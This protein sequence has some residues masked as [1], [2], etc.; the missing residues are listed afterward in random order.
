MARWN[1]DPVLLLGFAVAIAGFVYFGSRDAARRAWFAAATGILAVL[2]V[3]PFCALTSAL[4]AA[5]VAHHVVLTAV[6]APLLA[7]A[8]P[9][10]PR[11]GIALWAG[12]HALVFWVWH[13]PPVYG[14]ALSSH[15]AYWLMQAT[16]LGS[17]VA[18]WS[19]VRAAPMPAA[20]A[21]LLATMVQM[22]LLGALITFAPA[23]LYA[24]HYLG[25]IAWGFTPLEDQQLAGLIMW[26]PGAAVYLAAALA[27]LSRWFARE[28][29]AA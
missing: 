8:L 26:A 12:L 18:L 22:G 28:Q 5:R 1:F 15:G 13:A 16:L 9:A 21:A 25:P 7:A 19:A 10:I 29:A 24:P 3:S 20:I 23:P 14:W 4:F 27:L 6:A 17:A 11:G 2:F